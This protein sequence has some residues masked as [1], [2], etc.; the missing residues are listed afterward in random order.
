M[1][2]TVCVRVLNP[3]VCTYVCMYVCMYV[4]TV[5]SNGVVVCMCAGVQFICTYIWTTSYVHV[6]VCTFVLVNLYILYILK[7]NSL[8]S[9]QDGG[10]ADPLGHGAHPVLK[11]NQHLHWPQAA[12]TAGQVRAN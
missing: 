4:C 11:D 8:P 12:G 9:I 5:C 2:T 7:C 1:E 10:P 3:Y 6:Y